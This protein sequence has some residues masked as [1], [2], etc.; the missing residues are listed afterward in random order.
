M[1]SE[2]TV[3]KVVEAGMCC[4]CMCCAATCPKGAVAPVLDRYGYV[5]P[6]VDGAMCVA[7]GLCLKCC[8]MEQAAGRG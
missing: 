4:G 8:P 5:V 1:E 7:C 2:K 3:R 6:K